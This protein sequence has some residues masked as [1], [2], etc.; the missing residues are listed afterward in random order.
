MKKSKINQILEE[1]VIALLNDRFNK[2]GFKYK[3]SI[4]G[5]H[6]KNEDFLYEITIYNRYDIYMDTNLTA[7]DDLYLTFR[8]YFNTELYKFEKWYHEV[9]RSGRTGGDGFRIDTFFE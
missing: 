7:P 3:K 5:F 9:F 6:M 8:M 1:R 2:I 4:N